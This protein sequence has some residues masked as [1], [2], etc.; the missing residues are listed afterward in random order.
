MALWPFKSAIEKHVDSAI[1]EKIFEQVAREM[2][3]NEI[4]PGLWAKAFS[5]SNGDPDRTR[6]RYISL[7][8]NSIVKEIAAQHELSVKTAAQQSNEPTFSHTIPART[9]ESIP[10]SSMDN[11]ATDA[12]SPRNKGAGDF[13]QKEDLPT[14]QEAAVT[15]VPLS[16]AVA[17]AVISF[18]ISLIIIL[19]KLG[20]N[21]EN[22]TAL[23]G[24]P[25]AFS[26]FIAEAIGVSF[27]LPVIHVALASI[28]ESMRNSN[29]RRKIFIGWAIVVV[30]ANFI[31]LGVMKNNDQKSVSKD[32]Q[33]AVARYPELGAQLKLKDG[34]Q[35]VAWFR[36]AAEQ[37]DADAQYSL[38]FMYRKGE[39]VPKDAQHGA[40]WIKKAAEQRHAY[41]QYS[42]GFM[43]KEGEG[44]SKDAQQ[45]VAWFRKAAEQGHA[46]AQNQ[47]GRMY[48]KGEGVP[49]DDQQSAE[50]YH[51]AAEQGD[52]DAQHS[53][54]FRYRLGEGVPK[55]DQSAY[56]WLLL[57]SAK[58]VHNAAEQRDEVAR[59]LSPE[60]RA[61]AQASARNW[62]PKTAAQGAASAQNKPDTAVASADIDPFNYFIQAGA[63][64]TPE[65]AEQQR[66]RLLLLGYQAKVTEREQ[67]GR[68]VYR[69]R[70]GPF[71]KKDDAD[72]TK[73]KLDSNAIETALVRVQR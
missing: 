65:E 68:T 38:G 57:A 63:F 13:T 28:F 3:S 56:F 9:S 45:A 4:R 69:V 26:E 71:D 36:K 10:V 53:L 62:Q 58:G 43:Y 25:A 24:H 33:Q 1:E 40:A 6:A 54:S 21:L 30:I 16:W 15:P 8:A 37:G 17:C 35:D 29:T 27:G 41:A 50:W 73:E 61:A 47:L 12:A 67:S 66:V 31:S 5:E 7:R 59:H 2:D 32:A 18:S 55:D 20:V 19:K 49:K 42:L 51:K 14:K 44:V 46:D 22:F 72:K 64:R 34:Q 23:V 48:G 52:A 70:L 39:G 11:T 60:Q